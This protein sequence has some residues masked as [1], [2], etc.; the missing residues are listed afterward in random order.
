M[1]ES[2][3]TNP[4]KR[5]DRRA[6]QQSQGGIGRKAAERGRNEFDPATGQPQ[7]AVDVPGPSLD[8][9]GDRPADGRAH[10]GMSGDDGG[11]VPADAEGSPAPLQPGRTEDLGAQQDERE[12]GIA[13]DRAERAKP[14]GSA[15]RGSK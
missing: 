7:G 4:D 5:T 6:P 14:A 2:V 11:H 1:Q 3:M 13:D 10:H 15:R 9:G 8:G 12:R